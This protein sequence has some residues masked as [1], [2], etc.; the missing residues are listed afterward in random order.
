MQSSKQYL[1]EKYL[2]RKS[3]MPYFSKVYTIAQ[4]MT[5]VSTG[6]EKVKHFAKSHARYTKCIARTRIPQK[7][8]FRIRT[9]PQ[10]ENRHRN[11][12]RM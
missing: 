10:K 9:I 8:K 2:T 3:N 5:I 7:K 1:K 11:Q 6:L 4:I 12:Y